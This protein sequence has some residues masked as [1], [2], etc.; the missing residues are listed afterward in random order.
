MSLDYILDNYLINRQRVNR[1]LAPA[2]KQEFET[3][4]EK[5]FYEAGFTDKDLRKMC[6]CRSKHH[7]MLKILQKRA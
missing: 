6:K 1:A 2:L 5:M 7:N 4:I 3:E